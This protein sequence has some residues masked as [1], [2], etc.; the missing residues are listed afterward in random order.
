[1]IKDNITRFWEAYRIL[2]E[3]LLHMPSA[4]DRVASGL[5]GFLAMYEEDLH[6]GL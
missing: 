2:D 1:M 6:V 3:F 4:K 5:E